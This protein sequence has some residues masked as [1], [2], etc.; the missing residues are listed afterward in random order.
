MIYDRL[1]KRCRLLLVRLMLAVAVGTTFGD[2]TISLGFAAEKIATEKVFGPEDPGGPYKHPA[3]FDQ[4]NNGDLYLVFYGGSGEYQDDTA[5]FGA[6]K[7]AGGNSWSAPKIIADTPNRSEGNA[8]VWQAPD[9]RV[10]LFYLTR[11]GDTWSTSRIKAKVS[12]DNAETWSDSFLIAFEQG[13][14]VR[15]HP[16]VLANGDYL[17]PVYHEKGNDTE[18]V[19]SESTS[20]FLR[21]SK[22][23]GEWS[24]T[25]RIGFKIGCIQPAVAR[26]TDEYLVCYNRRGG[27]Y[28]PETRG[29]IVRSESR[30][31]G[32]T[33][34]QGSATEW[35]NPNAALDFLNLA[36]GH[37]VLIYNDSFHRRTPLVMT[38]STDGDKT[39]PYRLTLADGD[40]PYAYPFGI[41]TQDGK[42][43]VI[44]TTNRRSTIMHCWLDAA[45]VI[46]SAN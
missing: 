20:L 22:Q 33:W 17:L 13:M 10:W 1:S 18:S 30:D 3:S 28:R 38:I 15:S 31:G 45:D 24:E 37:L 11:Y 43:H 34:S 32:Q 25:N 23:S 44:Y 41:Q 29:F 6:R 12:T 9:G 4:L 26:V 36:N 42:I 14:M 16:V 19:G 40:G 8:V 7:R 27:D 39:Y 2:Q 46:S 35:P 5:I 21:S